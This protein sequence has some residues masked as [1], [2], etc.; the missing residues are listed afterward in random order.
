MK[1]IIILQERLN[2]AEQELKTLTEKIDKIEACL[3]EMDDL[4]LEMKGLK[5]FLGRIHPDFKSQMPDIIK[6][7]N[8]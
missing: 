8:E 3:K 4:K 2:L 5:I 1:D 6:K 7:L